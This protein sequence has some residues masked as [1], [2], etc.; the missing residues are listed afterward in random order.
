MFANNFI[1]FKVFFY[2]LFKLT[3][4]PYLTAVVNISKSNPLYLWRSSYNSEAFRE[5]KCL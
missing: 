3:P 2:I 4:V 1:V 5:S